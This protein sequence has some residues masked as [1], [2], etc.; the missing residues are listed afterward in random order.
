MQVYYLFGSIVR[1]S[2][3]HNPILTEMVESCGSIDVGKPRVRA[4]ADLIQMFGLLFETG[5]LTWSGREFKAVISS[6][7]L[8]R[9]TSC[10][11]N[12]WYVTSPKYVADWPIGAYIN[13][14]C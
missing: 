4:W 11:L 2:K 12:D 14:N 5:S 3:L 10:C 1:R 8:L 13:N 6:P 7:V 9:P